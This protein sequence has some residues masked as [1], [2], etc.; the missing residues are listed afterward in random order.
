MRFSIPLQKPIDDFISSAWGLDWQKIRLHLK[1]TS[2]T[3]YLR[4]I[5][6]SDEGKQETDIGIEGGKHTQNKKKEMPFLIYQVLVFVS[7]IN[8]FFLIVFLSLCRTYL[9][10]V[11]FVR[12]A[13]LADLLSSVRLEYRESDLKC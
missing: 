2:K 5:N 10:Q 11:N 6:D 4:G 13:S 7:P 3:L 1:M 8:N 12:F 9:D